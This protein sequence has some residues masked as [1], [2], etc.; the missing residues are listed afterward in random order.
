PGRL[1]CSLR[2][3]RRVMNDSLSLV[4][5]LFFQL[6]HV[7]FEILHPEVAPI[8]AV[9]I[10]VEMWMPTATELE[11]LRNF[12]LRQLHSNFLLLAFAQNGQSNRCSFRITADQFRKL[13]GLSQNLI[14]QHFENV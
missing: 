3:H 14:V 10:E 11:A 13:I 8:A 6:A 4:A 12:F 2:D 9:E 5:E 7:L 1:S